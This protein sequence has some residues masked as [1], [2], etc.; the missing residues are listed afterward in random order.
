[1]LAVVLDQLA[2]GQ[3]LGTEGLRLELAGLLADDVDDPVDPVDQQ[4]AH[5]QYVIEA[6]LEGKGTPRSECLA[7][8]RNRRHHVRGPVLRQ[9]R[10]NLARTGVE[11]LEAGLYVSY[12]ST[13]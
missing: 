8:S 3:H 4:I 13:P 7:G 11:R 9:V 12:Q 5:R 1:V 6:L 10:Q 2:G